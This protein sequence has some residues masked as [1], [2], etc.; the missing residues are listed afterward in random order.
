M[1]LVLGGS[2]EVIWN[3]SFWKN[4]TITGNKLQQVW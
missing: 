1:K 2:P 4:Y 3:K